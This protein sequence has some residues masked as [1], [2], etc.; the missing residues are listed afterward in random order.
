MAATRHLGGTR[1]PRG[2]DAFANDGS[3]PD[4]VCQLQIK[5]LNI[6]WWCTVSRSR[7]PDSPPR[8]RAEQYSASHLIRLLRRQA[9]ARLSTKWT[10]TLN[11]YRRLM[12]VACPTLHLIRALRIQGHARLST[13][14]TT[15]TSKSE[16]QW[17]STLN[18]YTRLNDSHVPDSTS[19]ASGTV[20]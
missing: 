19:S 7:V 13:N 6:K 14:T 3:L 16:C 15:G 10:S 4:P 12:T 11:S 2:E 20:L 17:T 18:S 9:H 8:P 1:V 5:G